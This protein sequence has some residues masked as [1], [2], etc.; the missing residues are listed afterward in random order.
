MLLAQPEFR[1]SFG[2]EQRAHKPSRRA[3]ASSQVSADVRAVWQYQSH[4]RLG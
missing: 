1:A 4:P 2:D 3:R